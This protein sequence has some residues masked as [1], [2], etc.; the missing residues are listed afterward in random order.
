MRKIHINL[1]KTETQLVMLCGKKYPLN[2][3]VDFIYRKYVSTTDKEYRKTI[4]KGCLR[5]IGSHY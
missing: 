5:R 2:E 1:Y 4:C 3:R